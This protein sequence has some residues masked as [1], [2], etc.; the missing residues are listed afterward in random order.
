MHRKWRRK[1]LDE[2]GSPKVT[3]LVPS[4]LDHL[5]C[6]KSESFRGQDQLDNIPFHGS[7]TFPTSLVETQRAVVQLLAKRWEAKRGTLKTG[8]H[9][10]EIMFEK[11]VIFWVPS[12]WFLLCLL[13][14]SRVGPGGS[15]GAARG[16]ARAGGLQRGPGF[17]PKP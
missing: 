7:M 10:G 11:F 13:Q 17:H 8:V 6:W 14:R 2:L 1:R 9:S 15:L 12:R 5:G 4:Y 3:K 16:P